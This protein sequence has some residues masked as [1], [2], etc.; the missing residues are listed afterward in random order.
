MHAGSGSARAAAVAQSTTA[1]GAVRWTATIILA[2]GSPTAAAMRVLAC[3]LGRLR[4]SSVVIHTTHDATRGLLSGALTP[5]PSALKRLVAAARRAVMGV[6]RCDGVGSG[7]ERKLEELL[8]PAAQYFAGRV[9]FSDG[10]AV[11]LPP[12]GAKRART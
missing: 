2:H 5:R 3:A 10:F 8:A 4:G 7:P 1:A 9:T 6:T 11:A 12:R